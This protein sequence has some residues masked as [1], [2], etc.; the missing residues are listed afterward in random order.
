MFMDMAATY[1]FACIRAGCGARRCPSSCPVTASAPFCAPATPI[2][3]RI[4]RASTSSGLRVLHLDGH[5]ADAALFLRARGPR[6]AASSS[7]STAA[8]CGRAYLELLDFV[9]VAIVSERLCEQMSLSETEMLAFLKSKGCR[10]GGVTTGEK[11][12]LWYDETGEISRL[13]A[14]PVPQGEGHRHIG[15]GRRASTAPMSPPFSSGRR[16]PGA[17]ISAMRGRPRRSRSSISAMRPACRRRTTSRPRS[18]RFRQIGL[19]P[20]RATSRETCPWHSRRPCY[21]RRSAIDESR[22]TC[23]PAARR[24]GG[25]SVEKTG[26]LERSGR[27][28]TAVRSV[29][30]RPRRAAPGSDRR[31]SRSACAAAPA[32]PRPRTMSMPRSISAPI[33]AGC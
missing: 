17:S 9:D 21:T 26:T 5:M 2:S 31:R 12:M 6:D 13:P 4:S 7:R 16:R 22:E 8:G 29:R 33:I 28:T 30:L 3:S 14:L 18:R 20:R 10:I 15:R 1:G 19:S 24:P 23:S 25:R 11:G 27:R 32:R